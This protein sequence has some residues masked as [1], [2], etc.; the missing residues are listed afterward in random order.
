MIRIAATVQDSIVDGPGLRFT[1]FAQ[2]CPHGCRGCH[3]PHTHSFD[4][5]RMASPEELLAQIFKNPLTDGVTL[6]GGEPMCQAKEFLPLVVECRKRGLNIWVYTGYLFEELI[7]MND[8]LRLLQNIDVLV[9]GPFIQEERSL[10]LVFRG[11]K[12]QRIIDVPKS[13]KQ[14]RAVLIDFL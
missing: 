12:N 11:S 8:C 13:L 7:C 14:N 3:N 9:D 6:S 4:G 5:G 1:V 2:G 10:D